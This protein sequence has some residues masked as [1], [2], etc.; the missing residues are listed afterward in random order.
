MKSTYGMAI[1]GSMLVLGGYAPTLL[2]LNE[3]VSMV[4]TFDYSHEV[5]SRA[6]GKRRELLVSS[7]GSTATGGT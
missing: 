1:A 2:K 6:C 3:L 7:G 4:G 5:I